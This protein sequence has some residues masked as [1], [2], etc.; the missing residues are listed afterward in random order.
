MPSTATMNTI[1]EGLLKVAK[2]LTGLMA[3]PGT[4]QDL[5]FLTD[6]QTR[7]LGYIQHANTPTGAGNFPPPGAMPA[8]SP[9][10]APQDGGVPPEIQ[11]MLGGGAQVS[12][13]TPAGGP[14]GAMPA[15][16]P[17]GPAGPQLAGGMPNPD[18]LRRMMQAG[19]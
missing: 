16:P 2:D 17:P 10:P 4:E 7:V 3:F 5:A 6:L 1:P 18:E 19:H 15:G 12:G 14:P 11:A 13:I 9:A 8:G